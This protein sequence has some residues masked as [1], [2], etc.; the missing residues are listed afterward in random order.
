MTDDPL[1][2]CFRA[3]PNE[4]THVSLGHGKLCANHNLRRDNT[5]RL[6]LGLAC[7][8]LLAAACATNSSVKERIDPLNDRLTSLEQ[9]QTGM[10]AKLNDISSKTDAQSANV[11]ALRDDLAKANAAA[12]Q[13]QTAANE[14][15]AAAARAEAAASKSTKAFE[16]KQVKGKK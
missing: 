15:Q 5:M 14:A 11:Q 12:Q 1:G 6:S 16:L 8:A 2:R 7:F 4:T 13:A 3:A 10:D 9:R